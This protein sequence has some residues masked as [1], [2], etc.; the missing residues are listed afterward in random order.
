MEIT[1]L[2]PDALIY[3]TMP[4]LRGDY[5]FE[6]RVNRQ[7]YVYWQCGIGLIPL[8]KK[9]DRIME[10]E[11]IRDLKDHIFGKAEM[12]ERRKAVSR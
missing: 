2:K 4:I 10:W 5:V 12:R 11:I 6:V 8:H 1:T 9:K 7:T 3:K